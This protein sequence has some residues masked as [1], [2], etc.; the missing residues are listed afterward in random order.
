[1]T[2]DTKT[3]KRVNIMDGWMLGKLTIFQIHFGHFPI[4]P[5]SL[6]FLFTCEV[7]AELNSVLT[8]KPCA[9]DPVFFWPAKIKLPI[10]KAE[11]LVG[12]PRFLACN[13]VKMNGPPRYSR[14]HNKCMKCKLCLI[15][16]KH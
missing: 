1:M 3:K 11:T 16:S 7:R 8:L 5:L 2:A 9:T 14:L 4:S 10:H 12:N 13:I 15:L 6:Q